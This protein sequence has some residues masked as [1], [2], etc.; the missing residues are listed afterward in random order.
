MIL[1]KKFKIH[2]HSM[3]PIFKEGSEILVSFVPF[4]F[5]KPKTG[6]IIAF[7]HFDKVL[8][9]RVK[10]AKQSRYLVEGENVSDSLKIGWIEKK[11]IIGKVIFKL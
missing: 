1:L 9:K 3:E 11:D 4:F 6:D 8:V 10:K 5:A 2:G 7:W